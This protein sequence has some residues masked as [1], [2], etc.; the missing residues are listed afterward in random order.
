MMKPETMERRILSL[1]A[2]VRALHKSLEALQV[3][4]RDR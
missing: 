3:E 4:E 2:A 1:E